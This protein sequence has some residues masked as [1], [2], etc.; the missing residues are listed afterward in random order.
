EA[1]RRGIGLEHVS[2]WMSRN[3]S[4]LVGLTTKGRIE[5]GADADLAVYDTGVEFRIEATRLAHRNPISAYDGI[6][7]GGRVTRSVVRGNAIDVDR[8]D[9]RWGQQLRR[10][11]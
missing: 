11:S 10:P 5:V 4:D 2:R 1:R 9:H 6:T 3:T 7:Y 8:P